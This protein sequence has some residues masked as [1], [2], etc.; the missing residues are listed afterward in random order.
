MKKE[1]R[2]RKRKVRSRGEETSMEGGGRVE[3]REKEDGGGDDQEEK[4]HRSEERR[5]EKGK[6]A[7]T[8][9]GDQGRGD[10]VHSQRQRDERQ[11]D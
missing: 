10:A 8:P 4:L 1:V 5:Q 7:D 11:L 3:W 2:R 9:V 6:T